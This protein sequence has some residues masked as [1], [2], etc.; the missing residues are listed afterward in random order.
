MGSK[1]TAKVAHMT[2][3]MLSGALLIA[4]LVLAGSGLAEAQSVI[5]FYLTPKIGSGTHEDPY[6][7]K[8]FVN[9]DGTKNVSGPVS[10]QY[11]D[12]GEEP[13]FLVMADATNAE[14]NAIAANADVVAAPVNMDTHIAGDLAQIRSALELLK[15]PQEFASRASLSWRFLFRRISSL[16]MFA[17][18]FNGLYNPAKL[19]PSGVDINTQFQ[20]LDLDT[21]LRYMSTAKTFGLILY[22]P[23]GNVSP[24]DQ[25]RK[26]FE[27]VYRFVPYNPFG[28]NL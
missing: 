7:A 19:L 2:R 6:R 24:Q 17:G 21:Q 23:G 11:M 27:V 1:V 14:H 25:L 13:V 20:N 10:P 4:A 16:F 9:A 15:I 12:Y 8:Y 26:V 3:R 28:G 22:G 18:R 5:H